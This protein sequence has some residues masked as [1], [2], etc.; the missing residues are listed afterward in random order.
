M[1]HPQTNFSSNF[2]G[3]DGNDSA[4]NIVVNGELH[5]YR[6]SGGD[7]EINITEAVVFE[8]GNSPTYA[9][10]GAVVAAHIPCY[11]HVSG[12]GVDYMAPYVGQR[13]A[14][15]LYFAM[16]DAQTEVIR[17]WVC[18][19][20]GPWSNGGIPVKFRQEAK[21]LAGA[22]N[23]TVTNI[24]QDENGVITVAYSAIAFPDWTSAINAAVAPCEKTANKKTT[25]TGFESSNTYYPTIKAVVDLVN[26]MLQNLGGKLITDNGDPFTSSA[27][28]PSSTPY[29]GVNIADKD[30]A[31]VQG[32]GTAERWSATVSG[33]SVT[34]LQEYA[35]SI[36]VFT[37]TQQAAIDSGAT[38]TKINNYESHINNTNIHVTTS[39]KNA[40]NAKQEALHKTGTVY[41][42]DIS[43]RS[44]SVSLPRNPIDDYNSLGVGNRF[45]IAEMGPSASNRPSDH[46]YH[47]S[48]CIGSDSSYATQVATCMTTL[49]SYYRVKNAGTWSAWSSI[50]LVQSQVGSVTTPVYVDGNGEL[51][52]CSLPSSVQTWSGTSYVSGLV[53]YSGGV[54]R[55]KANIPMNH[56]FGSGAHGFVNYEIFATALANK[57][58]CKCSYSI[59]PKYTGGGSGIAFVGMMP[60]QFIEGSSNVTPKTSLHV[61]GIGSCSLADETYLPNSLGVEIIVETSDWS[62]GDSV[63]FILNVSIIKN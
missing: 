26:G 29:G 1:A 22:T 41:D 3:S 16:V 48:T 21:S 45:M 18:N 59:T 37:P 15:A 61:S 17:Y 43:G 58:T 23:K 63:N 14:N 4:L 54:Y 9:E 60:G 8:L 6:P 2:Q 19:N 33:S 7:Q 47:V 50:C 52:E 51:K 42:I 38:S 34:W 44:G 28:L 25:V 20:G 62:V 5:Q 35:I 30:Y 53:E 27:S 10:V 32:V 49:K 11:L 39:E 56:S 40:W 46:W 57:G 12:N 31:Y 24:S 55:I 13:G 36:P